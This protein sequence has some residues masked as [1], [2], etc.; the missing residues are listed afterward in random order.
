MPIAST[1]SHNIASSSNLDQE[2]RRTKRARIETS[3]GAEF[4]LAFLV[5]IDL[6]DE[7]TMNV[8]L[9]EED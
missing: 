6:L 1:L 9:I 2:P 5:Q 7:Q 8:Y 3:F 4:V